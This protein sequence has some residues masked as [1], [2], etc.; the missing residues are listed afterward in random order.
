M[1]WTYNRTT[2]TLTNPEGLTIA[3]D[4]YSGAGQG[5]NNPSMQNVQN[6]GPIPDGSY[7]VG[8]AR[9]ST[10]T[11]AVS[12]DLAPEVGTDT[13]GRSA[14]M[15]HGDNI[16]HTASHGCII[17]RRAVREQINQSTDRR[18]IVR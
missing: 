2:G 18:L 1:P 13:H 14:F 12:M 5:R 17:L 3:N 15:I 10:R 11:G 16:S 4:G 7:R 6:I 9:H 8:N